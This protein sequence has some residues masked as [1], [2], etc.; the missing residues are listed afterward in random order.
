MYYGEQL[1]KVSGGV[2]K[3]FKLLECPACGSMRATQVISFENDVKYLQYKC[4]DCG[5][6]IGK[7]TPIELPD[8][9]PLR[10]GTY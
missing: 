8:E 5:S 7:K 9:I 1:E 10:P 6:F 2:Q 3:Q 4:L